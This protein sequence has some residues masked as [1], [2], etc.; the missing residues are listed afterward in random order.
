MNSAHQPHWG[1]F[2]K[3]A[4]SSVLKPR[5]SSQVDRHTR[6]L[7]VLLGLQTSLNLG[8]QSS[9]GI[10]ARYVVDEGSAI[11]HFGGLIESAELRLLTVT[12]CEMMARVCGRPGK[13]APWS[14]TAGSDI[15][16]EAFAG[17]KTNA[18]EV[19]C[20]FR[21][22]MHLDFGSPF[23]THDSLTRPHFC[24]NIRKAESCCYHHRRL[25][26]PPFARSLCLSISIQAFANDPLSVQESSL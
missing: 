11:G 2:A 23:H 25:R 13:R 8:V 26:A 18:E 9:H 21:L 10:K 19:V 6:S 12:H 1:I 4:P 15:H 5:M 7:Q 3:N 14:A 24:S 22:S 16:Y 17:W 20:S